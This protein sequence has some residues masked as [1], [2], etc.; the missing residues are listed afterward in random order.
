VTFSPPQDDDA[1]KTTVEHRAVFQID[2]VGTR[3]G[4]GTLTLELVANAVARDCLTPSVLDFGVVPINR[5]ISVSL[6]FENASSLA[7]APLIGELAGPDA[8]FFLRSGAAPESL[9]PGE[10]AEV[11]FTFTPTSERALRC[12]SHRAPLAGV[13]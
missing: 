10:K 6:H 7:Q 11:P 3:E 4:E 12:R 2:A 9:A 1:T 8:V 5:S 13:P